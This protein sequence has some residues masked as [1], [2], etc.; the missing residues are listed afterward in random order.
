MLLLVPGEPQPVKSV[1]SEL[2]ANNARTK[3]ASD[4][5][6]RIV[7]L[8]GAVVLRVENMVDSHL[9]SFKKGTSDLLCPSPPAQA[10]Q[11]V[12]FIPEQS[13]F[14]ACIPWSSWGL[15]IHLNPSRRD[16]NTGSSRSQ[17]LRCGR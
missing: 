13:R 7:C 17:Q 9:S 12:L 14:R 8:S 4:L 6:C 10:S 2:R 11:T 16:Q 15:P 3:K 1:S 5:C